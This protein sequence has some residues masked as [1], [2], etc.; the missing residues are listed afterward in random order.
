MQEAEQMIAGGADP[1]QAYMKSALKYG[2]QLSLPGSVYSQAFK[3]DQEQIELGVATEVEGLPEDYRK[4]RTGEGSYQLVKLP[5]G[6]ADEEE[7]PPGYIR[8]GERML[9]EREPREVTDL[10]AERKRLVAQQDKDTAGQMMADRLAGGESELTRS[11]KMLAERFNRRA[12]EI[13]NLDEQIKK[14]RGGSEA[15]PRFKEGQRVR[16]PRTGQMGTY[17]DGEIVPDE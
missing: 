4:F 16:N 10:K 12:T 13:Q 7:S 1:E 14:L 3:P 15:A 11:Q 2:P 5:S 6:I 9:P 17:V 8:F